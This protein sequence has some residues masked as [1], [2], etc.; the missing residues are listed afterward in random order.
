MKPLKC[1]I[2]R[3]IAPRDKIYGFAIYQVILDDGIEE[4]NFIL[5]FKHFDQINHILTATRKHKS[6]NLSQ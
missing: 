1:D 2:C 6:L 4:K 3:E 5:C